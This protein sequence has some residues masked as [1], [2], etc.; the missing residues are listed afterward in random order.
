MGIAA[1]IGMAV[2]MFGL[3]LIYTT[4]A[5]TRRTNELAKQ[6][7][8]ARLIVIPQVI[9]WPLLQGFDI[10]LQAEN[11]GSSIAL[12]VSADARVYTSPPEKPLQEI[13]GGYLYTIKSGDSQFLA[14]MED[15]AGFKI[16]DHICG[17]II[18]HSIFGGP[19]KTFF[20]YEI[21]EAPPHPKL[22]DRL[23][24]ALNP[25]RPLTWPVDT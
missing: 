20:S 3:A 7:Q 6:H 21:I 9:P 13:R 17:I 4:Y 19:H 16:G 12:S 1:I 15:R 5:E 25:S 14:L 10:A 24:W 8:R 2:G 23:P 11:V 18:Y 22:P